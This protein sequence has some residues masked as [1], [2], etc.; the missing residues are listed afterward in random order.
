MHLDLKDYFLATPM[1][2]PEHVRVKLK[3]MPEDIRKHYNTCDIVTKD[4]WV[5][6]KIQKGMSSLRQ[7]A[8]L[9]HK[10]IKNS[11]EPS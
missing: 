7:A 10:H 3:H 11:L 9:A 1:Q 2:C 4:D 8:I 5:Y 6:V